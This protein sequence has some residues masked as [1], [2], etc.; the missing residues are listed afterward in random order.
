MLDELAA[1]G[2]RFGQTADDWR[3]SPLLFPDEKS[4]LV[5]L[6]AFRRG[7]WKHALKAAG[8]R[9]RG[10]KQ[11]RHTFATL[12]LVY[13]GLDKL[14]DVSL[15]LRHDRV[16]TTED[17]YLAIVQELRRQAAG[18]VAAGMP[19]YSNRARRLIG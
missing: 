6:D 2:M 15:A 7:P 17:F 9:H 8:V 3:S 14:K 19:L 5:N 1:A 18:H 4:Q 12:S 13:G 16:S 10:F 11:C